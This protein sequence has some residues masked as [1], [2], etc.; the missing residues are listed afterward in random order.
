MSATPNPPRPAT[1]GPSGLAALRHVATDMHVLDYLAHAYK[2]RY[3]AAGVLAAAIL[4]ALVK[5][6]TTTPMYRAQARVIIELED[7]Q[8]VSTLSGIMAGENVRDPAPYYQT[9]FRILT[10]RELARRTVRSL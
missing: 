7:D 1:T 6:Y 10:G 3:L 2:Y 9:Q 4:V 8:V 5:T